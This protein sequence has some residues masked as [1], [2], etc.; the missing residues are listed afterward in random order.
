MGVLEFVVSEGP[1]RGRVIPLPSGRFSVGAAPDC[2]VRLQGEGVAPHHA[3]VRADANGAW[4]IKDL[5]AGRLQLDG[6]PVAQGVLKPGSFVRLGAVELALR[7]R[8]KT[9]PSGTIARTPAGPRTPVKTE[10]FSDT[11]RRPSTSP[12]MEP[13]EV[14][15]AEDDF[16]ARTALSSVLPPGSVIDG[17][18]E[19]LEKLAEGGMG[20]VYRAQHVELGKPLAV[21]VMRPE[22][23]DD[24][25]FV[26]RFKREAI[27]AGRIGQQNI[28]DVSDFGRTA[29]GRFYF[30]MEFL[31]GMTVTE[32]LRSG[33]GLP[34]KRVVHLFTQVVRALAAAHSQGI[35]HRDL[36]P[37]NIMVLQRPGQPD[38]VKVLDFGIAKVTRGKA[39]GGQTAVGMVVG[40]PQYMAPEQAQGL[41]SDART[42]IYALGLILYEMLLGRPAFNAET[43]SMLMIKQVTEPPQRFPEALVTQMPSELEQLVF[44]MLEKSP[45]ARPQAMEE[46][47]AVLERFGARGATAS[48]TA[49]K[50]A[51]PVQPAPAKPAVEEPLLPP[52][53]S[54]APLLVAGVALLGVVAAVVLGLRSGNS[55]PSE[56]AARRA[57]PVVSAPPAP[58][59]AAPSSPVAPAAAKPAP[60]PA[61][62]KATFTFTVPISVTATVLDGDAVLGVT[63][64]R[65]TRDQGTV[66]ELLF[67]APGYKDAR[68]KVRFESDQEFPV[69]LE[70]LP[71]AP[72]VQI[73]PV[74]PPAPVTAPM[75]KP[76]TSRQTRPDLKEV[77]L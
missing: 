67:R 50:P 76:A 19:V 16:S 33:D 28:I 63:P 31:D 66:M 39:A 5:S 36:K 10:K 59:A 9:G 42:D 40:T 8:A 47:L 3:E 52:P 68:V 13:L 7:E 27:S 24:P 57:A 26:A 4:W 48:R 70:P 62:P 32:L 18:Y 55:T 61:V 14:E 46:V 74:P 21:K 64:F 30:V 37:D 51:V 11:V 2:A 60:A 73:A 17:R 45:A 25:E 58:V 54:R 44:R 20:E 12:G 65:L 43:P 22:L 38:F 56:P 72:P 35:V 1:E 75:R 69:P 49:V 34:V 23:S 15:T 6:K 77:D 41:S 71:A 29:S 53:R